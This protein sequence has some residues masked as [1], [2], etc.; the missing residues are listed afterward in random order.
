M[1]SKGRTDPIRVLR[2]TLAG[3]AA[4]AL[5]H[6]RQVWEDTYGSPPDADSGHEDLLPLW[7]VA[8]KLMDAYNIEKGMT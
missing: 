1:N 7:E 2:N 6:W 8:G 3:D 5:I 4:C